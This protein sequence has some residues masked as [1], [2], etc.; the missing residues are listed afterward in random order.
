MYHNVRYFY[1]TQP[2]KSSPIQKTD[3]EAKA[4]ARSNRSAVDAWVF[5]QLGAATAV[6]VA[7]IVVLTSL[8]G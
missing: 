3:G 8:A 4:V 5:L 2:E 7:A 1:M 6:V